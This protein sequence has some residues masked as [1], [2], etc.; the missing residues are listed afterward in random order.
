[1]PASAGRTD[2]LK[3]RPRRLLNAV[4]VPATTLERPRGTKT[5]GIRNVWLDGDP[6]TGVATMTPR[7]VTTPPTPTVDVSSLGRAAN[8]AADTESETWMVAVWPAATVTWVGEMVMTSPA[9]ETLARP[10]L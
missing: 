1:M 7:A 6:A 8:A 5:Y 9:L 10:R 4:G 2:P 3:V